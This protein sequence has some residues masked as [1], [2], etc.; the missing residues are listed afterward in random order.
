MMH[1]FATRHSSRGRLALLLLA[2]PILAGCRSAP[3]AELLPPLT[4]EVGYEAMAGTP[5]IFAPTTAPQEESTA[6]TEEPVTATPMPT[7]RPTSIPL[8]EGDLDRVMRQ[9]AYEG[10]VEDLIALAEAAA[11]EG[12]PAGAEAMAA[13]GR[14]WGALGQG[15]I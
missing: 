12:Y 3:V 11:S 14:A 7:P 13:L 9:L 6:A 2:L 4:A 5:V 1:G 15:Q 8:P 10:R